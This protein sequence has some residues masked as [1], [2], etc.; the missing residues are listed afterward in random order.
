MSAQLAGGCWAVIPGFRWKGGGRWAEQMRVLKFGV[1]REFWSL[2]GHWSLS[3]KK[4]HLSARSRKFQ[5]EGKDVPPPTC[6]P[7]TVTQTQKLEN[8][9]DEEERGQ[10]K[11]SEPGRKA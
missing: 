7:P 6:H 1:N 9:A 10:S 3:V 2:T 4:C 5:E 8:S 11:R